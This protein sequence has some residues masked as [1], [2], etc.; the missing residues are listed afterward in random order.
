MPAQ[1][2]VQLILDALDFPASLQATAASTRPSWGL[3]I[4]G[5]AQVFGDPE[6]AHIFQAAVEQIRG[7]IAAL[8]S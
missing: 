5:G 1:R 7:S 6:R 3:Q 2:K 8:A 4:F